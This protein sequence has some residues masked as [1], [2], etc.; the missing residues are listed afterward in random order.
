MQFM[1]FNLEKLVKNLSDNDFKYLTEEFASKNLELLKQKDA[2]PYE[3]IDS[4]I[5]FCEKKLSDKKCFYRSMKNR[6]TGDNGEE[7]D[8]QLE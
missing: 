1:S 5:R 2:Y 3:Y 7:L 6:T 8:G 4:F